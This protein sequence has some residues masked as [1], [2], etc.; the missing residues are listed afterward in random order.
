M[1]NKVEIDKTLSKIDQLLEYP[2]PQKE[3]GDRNITMTVQVEGNP[4]A[5]HWLPE[6]PENIVFSM[7]DPEH[8]SI[9]LS[10]LREAEEILEDIAKD[11]DKFVREYLNLSHEY[12]TL[13]AKIEGS[14]PDSTERI[15]LSMQLLRC[16]SNIDAL[17]RKRSE[18]SDQVQDNG[19]G[20]SIKDI[21]TAWEKLDPDA[22]IKIEV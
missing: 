21:P 14:E 4:D 16:G 6:S 8:L 11:R 18:Y 2:E 10:K 7:K 22:I 3:S 12:D 20:W 9:D 17:L 5:E 15:Y 19:N 1:N 13:A